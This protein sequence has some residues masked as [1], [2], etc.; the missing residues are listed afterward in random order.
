MTPVIWAETLYVK[1]KAQRQHFWGLERMTSTSLWAY[2]RGLCCQC[3][4]SAELMSA[5]HT[6][7]SRGYTRTR[8]RGTHHEQSEETEDNGSKMYK[9]RAK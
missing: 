1:L 5:R 7:R 6:E 9:M 4:Q 2:S 8:G 3:G